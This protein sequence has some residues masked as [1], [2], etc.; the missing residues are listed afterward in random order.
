MGG[1]VTQFLKQ[2]PRDETVLLKSVIREFAMQPKA[3]AFIL[4]FCPWVSERRP[5]V[6]VRLSLPYSIK[7]H[8]PTLF[9]R[10]RLIF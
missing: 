6:S 7:S 1:A 5:W 2:L 3:S 9:R 8:T 10:D 4:Q